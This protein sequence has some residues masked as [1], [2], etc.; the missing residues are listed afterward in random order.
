MERYENFYGRCTYIMIQVRRS[1]TRKSQLWERVS[2]TNRQKKKKKKK[3]KTWGRRYCSLY[4]STTT[5]HY[6][7]TRPYC[8]VALQVTSKHY[9]CGFCAKH[10]GQFC[11]ETGFGFKLVWGPDDWHSANKK[12][13]FACPDIII[14]CKTKHCPTFTRLQLIRTHFIIINLIV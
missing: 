9:T 13:R 5:K 3:K 6:T 8:T 4:G 12:R 1:E 10:V 11:L 2:Y 14:R 7:S